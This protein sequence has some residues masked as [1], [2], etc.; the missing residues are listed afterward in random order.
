MCS[1]DMGEKFRSFG[2]HV[3]SVEDGNDC[4]QLLAA[5]REAA[6]VKGRPTVLLAHT[7]KGRG[8]S[9]MEGSVDWHGKAP[10]DEEYAVAMA[11]LEKIGE[12]LAEEEA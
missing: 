4:G 6:S 7:V 8:V 9:F 1:D 2:W 5:Y 12:E 10:G 11:D 3:I